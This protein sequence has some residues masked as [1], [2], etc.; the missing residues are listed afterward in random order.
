M[1]K[2]RGIQLAKNIQK[3]KKRNKIGK[4]YTEEEKEEYNWQRIYRR[5]KRKEEGGDK[6]WE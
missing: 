5:R 3:K 6:T 2:K 4:E 1:C